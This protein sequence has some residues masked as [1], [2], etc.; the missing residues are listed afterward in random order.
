MNSWIGTGIVGLL[1]GGLCACSTTK[2]L[3]K[4]E[5]LY[6]GIES[7]TV[8]DREHVREADE[9]LGKVEEALAYPPNNVLLGSSSKR[10]PFPLG[11]WMY[12]AHVDKKGAF[13][14]WMFRWLTSLLIGVRRRGLNGT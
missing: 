12:N 14:E 9:V 5:V 7:I 6:T 3:P 11:L 4:G 2:N 8:T 10:T 13:Y 1:L